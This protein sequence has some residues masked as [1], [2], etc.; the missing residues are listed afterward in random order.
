MSRIPRRFTEQYLQR[1]RNSTYQNTHCAKSDRGCESDT[2]TSSSES[3]DNQCLTCRCGILFQLQERVTVESGRFHHSTQHRPESVNA[4]RTRMRD[5]RPAWRKCMLTRIINL[6]VGSVQAVPNC[7]PMKARMSRPTATVRIVR[8]RFNPMTC[9]R[10]NTCERKS[11]ATAATAII[12]W[13]Q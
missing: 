5:H 9:F 10:T 7:I 6:Y 13:N 12:P 3:R 8:R 2:E 11:Q 1:P 4:E